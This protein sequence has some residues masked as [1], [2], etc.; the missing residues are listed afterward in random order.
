M[1]RHMDKFERLL[2]IFYLDFISNMEY[3]IE[4]YA[5]YHNI[6]EEESKLFLDIGKKYHNLQVEYFKQFATN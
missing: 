6:T 5:K 3:S 1:E 4:D 2:I